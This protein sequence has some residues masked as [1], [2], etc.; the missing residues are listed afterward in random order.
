MK[1]LWISQEPPCLP[2]R[3]GFALYGAS[4][5]TYL[6]PK[7]EIDLVSLTRPGDGAAGEWGAKLCASVTRIPYRQLNGF[8]RGLHSLAQ[9]G[10]GHSLNPRDELRE[11]IRKESKRAQWEIVHVE[12]DYAGGLLGS[13]GLPAV[14]SVHDAETLRLREFRSCVKSVAQSARLRL[15]EK[16][17]AR[18][19]RLVYPRF[20]CCLVVNGRDKE[21][22]EEI[23]PE[24]DVRVLPNG[25]DTNYFAPADCV[26]KS[27]EAAFHG[28]LSYPPNAEAAIHFATEILPLIRQR[29]PE[30]TFHV[31]GARPP[32]SVIELSGLAGVRIS[33][34][35]DDVR[36][37]LSAASVY[38]C[39]VR[40]GSGIKN[41]I[42][43]AMAL[44]LPV[45]SYKSAADGIGAGAG[46]Q[47]LL[48]E[49]ASEFAASVLKLFGEPRKAEEL[50]REGRS[51]VVER[52][53]WASRA[54]ELESIYAEQIQKFGAMR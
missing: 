22:I 39:A 50:A 1:I 6:A 37:L 27:Y 16:L 4:L 10:F 26:K 31:I 41:K 49:L 33:A 28:N 25:V 2:S 36:P 48:A 54:Q 43:E 44:K 3:N 15:L 30:A 29:Q 45:A 18:F 34:D 20:S 13:P 14:L 53:S 35:V 21:V 19:Q 17:E 9:F 47:I 24:A 42:L 5:L 51:F 7:H 23:V 8:T 52:Y 40:Y 12:G 11:F 46:R 32:R 38:V